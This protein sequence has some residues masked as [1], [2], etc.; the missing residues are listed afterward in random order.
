MYH[1]IVIE[2]NLTPWQDVDFNPDLYDATWQS[3]AIPTALEPETLDC[4]SFQKAD[5]S[6][7]GHRQMTPEH[8]D[9]LDVVAVEC[10][11]DNHIDAST[12]SRCPEITLSHDPRLLD[13]LITVF[14]QHF[15][16]V[17]LS[18]QD[19]QISS[20]TL[21]AHIVLMAALGALFTSIPDSH[22]MARLLVEDGQ[23]MLEEF[24][25]HQRC[26]SVGASTSLVQA[27]LCLEMFGLCS[28][29]K[30]SNEVSE[31]FH[32]ALV[33]AVTEHESW[34]RSADPLKPMILR[35]W[36]CWTL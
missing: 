26:Q 16:D 27:H 33:Q 8:L 15:S 19:L 14:R 22:I 13:A 3:L 20:Q 31:A 10:A 28:R 11:H 23:H 36:S 5:V 30:R 1:F 4:S 9:R 21:T 25:T 12:T 32:L 18:F 35:A 29:H 6:N 24:I 2:E 7:M 34:M 17:F